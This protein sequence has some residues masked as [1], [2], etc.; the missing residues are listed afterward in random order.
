[1][2]AKLI[3][4]RNEG[5]RKKTDTKDYIWMST[6]INHQVSHAFI[7]NNILKGYICVKSALGI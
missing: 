1:M 7:K 3:F 6:Q 5:K 2:S 4:L